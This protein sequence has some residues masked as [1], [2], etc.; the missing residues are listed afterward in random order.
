MWPHG[1]DSLREFLQYLNQQH[2]SIRFPIRNSL[3]KYPF[4]MFSSPEAQTA[5]F[6]TAFT[7]NPPT[8][9]VTS[10]SGPSIT[11]L[12]SC[13]STTLCA[14]SACL[15]IVPSLTWTASSTSC[16]HHYFSTAERIQCQ[17]SQDKQARPLTQESPVP[18]DKHTHTCS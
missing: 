18:M 14:G 13:Q 6:T 3:E 8:P 2:P 9:T 5:H 7:G 12:S 11:Q 17:A 10:I 16:H 15:Y 1:H 4:W